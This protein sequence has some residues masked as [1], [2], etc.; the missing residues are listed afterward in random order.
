MQNDC[1]LI[2]K[3]NSKLLECPMCGLLRW[4]YTQ[5]S[6]PKVPKK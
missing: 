5:N 6:E 1:M 4:K 2:W 3:D